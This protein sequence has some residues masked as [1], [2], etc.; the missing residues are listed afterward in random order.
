MGFGRWLGRIVKALVAPSL[1][2]SLSAFFVWHA[3]HGERGQVT[4]ELRKA[5][6]ETAVEA[7]DMARLE[8]ESSERRV[9]ALRGAALDRDQL[10]ER[11]RSMLNLTHPHEIVIPYPPGRRLY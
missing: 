10:E 2:L 3:Q 7:R 1:L 9:N 8:R 4:R 11:A 6:L 5:E